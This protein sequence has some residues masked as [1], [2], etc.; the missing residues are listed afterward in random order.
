MRARG[1]HFFHAVVSLLRERAG[2]A[3]SSP[4][5][6]PPC[7]V[8]DMSAHA[9]FAH[10]ASTRTWTCR[11]LQRKRKQVLALGVAVWLL[12]LLFTQSRWRTAAPHLHALIE[13]AGLVLILVC[14]LGRTWCTLYIGGLK[15]REL[16]TAGPY[17]VV[18][19]PLYVF[20]S[21]GTA[22]IGA[23]TGS[24]LVAILF[25]AGSLRGVPGRGAAR[26]S[27]PGCEPFRRTLPPTRRACP[28]S[29]LACRSGARP[30]SFASSRAWCAARSS[31]P[32]CFYWRC[33][34]PSLL[35][36]LQQ[37]GHFPVLLNLP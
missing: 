5:L 36:W 27:V 33:L 24:S 12:L 18:R 28:A 8:W 9:G 6:E 21:I 16:V 37:L 19:N 3:G 14:I 25:A 2:Q 1:R 7:P 22:G 15:K 13:I 34:L 4:E 17:S 26:G 23:Q 35:A 11:R 30:T 20:T 32:A 31:R 10:H 29:G